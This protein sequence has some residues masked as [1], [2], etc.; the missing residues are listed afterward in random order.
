MLP[1]VEEFMTKNVVTINADKTVFEAAQLMT[2]KEIGDLVVCDG[3][4][5]L[6]LLLNAILSG[7]LLSGKNR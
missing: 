2:E 3:R 4:P 7:A 6:E 5:Q 1:T